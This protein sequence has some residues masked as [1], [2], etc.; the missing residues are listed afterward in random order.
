MN[1]RSHD[2]FLRKAKHKTIRIKTE[3]RQTNWHCSCDIFS[4]SWMKH[5]KTFLKPSA[6]LISTSWIKHTKK[7][8]KCKFKAYPERQKLHVV[9]FL[10]KNELLRRPW[11]RRHLSLIP[12]IETGT[13]PHHSRE[14]T[15]N[16]S[17]TCMSEILQVCHISLIP[18][19]ET[20]IK[21]HCSRELTGNNS[22]AC[23]SE[24][25]QVPYIVPRQSNLYKRSGYLYPWLISK[26]QYTVLYNHLPPELTGWCSCLENLGLVR[27]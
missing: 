23:V 9:F 27:K 15:G 10:D 18:T 6:K 19:I 7:N 24:L 12:T 22:N 26:Q 16:N 17:N 3:Q 8:S 13:K 5:T 1:N 21:P 2:S 11:N 14:L 20:C 4:L 25:L